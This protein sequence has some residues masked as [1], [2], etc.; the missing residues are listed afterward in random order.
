MTRT[1]AGYTDRIS[2]CPGE[3]IAFKVSAEDGSPSY[4]ASL[5]R[6]HCVDS[7]R[8]GP[9]LEEE[10][11]PSAFDGEHPARRQPIRIGSRATVEGGGAVSGLGSFSIAMM[12]WPTLEKEA[13]QVLFSTLDG[14][15]GGFALAV[16]AGNRLSLSIGGQDLALDRPLLTREWA[17]VAASYDAATGEAA[18]HAVPANVHAG[19]SPPQSRMAKFGRKLPTG[20]AGLISVAARLEPDGRPVEHYNGK[21]DS[22]RLLSRAL[23]LEALRRLIVEPL[24][25]QFAADL[26][27]AWDFSEDMGSE[28]AIDLSPNRLDCRLVNM[29]SRAAKGW[30]WSGGFQD[31]K[32]APQEYGAIHFHEDDLS[33]CA[34]E[35]DFTFTVPKNLPSGCYAAKLEG[36]GDPEHVVF[37]VRAPRGKPGA[38][39]VF[40]A[41][42]ATYI[43]YGN[44]RVMNR[45]NLYEMYLGQ[46]P[47]LVESDLFLNTRPEYGDS[48]YATHNDGS[49]M[50]IGTRLRPTVNMRPNTTLSAFN[51]DGWIFSWLKAMRLDADF[52]TDEDLH[53]EGLGL[54]SDYSLVITGNHP[55]YISTQMWDALDA[56]LTRGGRLM[57]LGGNGFFWRV[58]FHDDVPGVME[59]RR[60]EDGSRP[61]EAEPGEYYMAFNGEYGG[62]WR[63]VGRPPQGLVG[64]G[65]TASG[66]DISSFYRRTEQ[67]AD[68]RAAFIFDGV[69]DEI[70]GD[71]G[72]AGGGAAGQEIDRYDRALGSPPHALVVAR[73]EDH[74]EEMM[75]GKEDMPAANYIIGGTENPLVHADMTFFETPNGGAVFSTGSI[76]WAAGLPWNGFDNSVSRI[77]RNVFER[78]VDPK[79]FVYPASRERTA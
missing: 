57:Y 71:F 35:T 16:G 8:D 41:S 52:I 24:A 40:L 53:H 28:R 73:S 56:F 7:H 20:A 44:Y 66:F 37:F 29:P 59:L 26:V 9:G 21:I 18:L 12:I 14:A 38:R 25:A 70:I 54:L 17:L 76:T 30:N 3:T 39:A 74:T 48:L 68:P 42:T 77:T 49:G 10:T 60:A 47:E 46:L 15:G 79:P 55:E 45:S 50:A 64:V 32:T 31:W 4:R 34:W 36:Q 22:P 19:F 72:L 11:I 6:L 27:A 51:D 67:S 13:P 58:A 1:L 62:L 61:W 5:V 78:F 65:F 63:R 33:D 69:G 23:P 2:A 43:A 75:I